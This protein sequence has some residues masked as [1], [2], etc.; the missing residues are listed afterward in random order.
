MA[1]QLSFDGT[2]FTFAGG[3][4]TPLVSV[5]Y[6]AEAAEVDVGG[7]ADS[8]E[9]VAAGIKNETLTVEVLGSP[10]LSIGATGACVVTWGGGAGPTDGGIA[11]A[12][13][14]KIAPGGGLDDK[15]TTTYTFRPNT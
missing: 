4:L 5:R 8:T 6:S 12:I 14:T 15:I 11:D 9:V 2:T 10:T 7:A 13:L 3:A 1:V